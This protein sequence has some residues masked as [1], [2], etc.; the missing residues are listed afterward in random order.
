MLFTIYYLLFTIYYLLSTESVCGSNKDSDL[1]SCFGSCSRTNIS[2]ALAA[3]L[4]HRTARARRRID[5]KLQCFIIFAQLISR[6]PPCPS[7][8][9]KKKTNSQPY[10]SDGFTDGGME[11]RI[12]MDLVTSNFA[13]NCFSE[14]I[15]RVSSFT[16]QGF[17]S[18]D[19]F[20]VSKVIVHNWC[21]IKQRSGLVAQSLE[22][23]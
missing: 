17:S 6:F 12:H 11:V 20:K 18:K 15:K 8:P 13:A 2:F 7:L 16:F 19:T 21:M 1:S 4:N 9:E 23:Q 5:A 3:V 14:Y 10:A 22:Q